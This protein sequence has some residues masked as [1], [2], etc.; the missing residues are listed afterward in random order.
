VVIVKEAQELKNIEELLPYIE[1]PLK[2]TILVI[3]YKYKKIDNF[4]RSMLVGQ[5]A[6]AVRNFW[7]QTGRIGI[8]AVDDTMQAM[9]KTMFGGPGAKGN[10]YEGF[11]TALAAFNRMRPQSRAKLVDVLE[12]N[13]A[14]LEKMRLF[15]A[16]VH[17][18]QLG[19][20]ISNFVNA[21][22][23]TQEHFFRKIGFEA[24]LRSL[25]KRRGLDFN[26]VSPKE[27]PL[28]DIS[29]S[30]NYALE[31]SFAAAPKSKAGATILNAYNSL[32]GMT[33][34]NPFPRFNW[35]NAIP[36][37]AEH[38]PYGLL[39]AVSPKVLYQLAK[40]DSAAFAKHASRGVIGTMML[41][42][43]LRVRSSKHAGTRWYEWN[44]GK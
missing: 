13:S 15:S 39:K 6:T 27:I 26:T 8:G 7:S 14:V 42:Y 29:E 19:G 10:V 1:Q 21:L 24:K 31:M 11:N 35:F 41:D 43:A 12:K 20:K 34:I 25:L 40:G 16:P 17:E 44:T 37:I 4:R 5:V 18:V 33:L 3:C 22:N 23:K 9:A 28:D 2:T 38:S 30:V 32:P 36:F